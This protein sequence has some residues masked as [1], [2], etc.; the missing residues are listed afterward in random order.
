MQHRAIDHQAGST[1]QSLISRTS[2]HHHTNISEI[3][4]KMQ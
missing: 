2:S 1:K 4:T 3:R